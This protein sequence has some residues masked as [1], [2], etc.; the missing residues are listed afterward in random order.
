MSAESPARPAGDDVGTESVAPLELMRQRNSLMHSPASVANGREFTPRASDVFI[1]TYPKCGTTWMTQLCHQIR[2]VRHA[3]KLGMPASA[4]AYDESAKPGECFSMRFGEITEV[5]PWDILAFDCDQNLDDEQF[6]TGQ[7]PFAKTP[8]VP[9]LFKS[10]ETARNVARGAKYVC[11]ARD[12]A[13][14]FFSFYEFLP[15][16]M[17][18]ER[19]AVSMEAFC[20]AIFAGA[21]HSGDLWSHFLG[22]LDRRDENASRLA[23]SENKTENDVLMV[24]FEAMKA[25]P[26]GVARRLG[27]F[28]KTEPGDEELSETDLDFVVGMSGFER[29][30]LDASKFDDHFVRRKM[31][32]RVGI[33]ER[34]WRGGG[35]GKV[36]EG[37]GRVGG[38]RAGLPESVRLKIA[39][40]WAEIMAPR[41]FETY[42]DFRDAVDAPGDDG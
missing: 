23:E 31:W 29:M 1:V 13:D 41:G 36:R 14:V 39:E 42:A 11:V 10:H 3:K 19:G 16:Y 32:T 26:R 7:E 33:P 27:T 21:S 22:W 6:L 5:V 2:C 40:K 15:A 38:G 17:G 28:L 18:L 35:V 30:R 20:D 37:G 4:T 25:D 34:D 24:S 9:R 12:P 8:L